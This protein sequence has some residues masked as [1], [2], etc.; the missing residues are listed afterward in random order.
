MPKSSRNMRQ[1]SVRDASRGEMSYRSLSVRS[2]TLD[3]D[4]RTVDAIVSTETPVLMPDWQRMEMVP[5]VLQ[6]KGA[7]IPPSGQVPFLD[8][9]NRS[10]VS[11]QLGSARKIAT[12]YND[13]VAT[14][15][16]S[17]AAD[18]EFTKVREGHVTDVSA[19]YEVLK[20]TYVP[21]G[22]TQQVNG[23]SYTGPVNVATKWRLR[24]VS[25]TP[26]GA[27]A[28]AK[29]RGLD[30][31]A[32][33]FESPTE[34]SFEMDKELRDFLVSRGM[35]ATLNDADAQKWLMANRALLV[36]APAPVTTSTAPAVPEPTRAA[37]PAPQSLPNPQPGLAVSEQRIQELFTASFRDFQTK[38]EAAR[39][40]FRA[41][42]DSLCELAGLPD[43]VTHCRDLP[44]IAAVRKHLTDEKARLATV[45]P[46]QPSI[47]QTGSGFD[48]CMRDMGT[49]LALRAMNNATDP[50]HPNHEKTFEKV[51]PVASRGKGHETFRHATIFRMAEEF[52]RMLGIDTRDMTR[53]DIAICAM[54]GPD[55]IGKRA[56]GVA[57]YNQTG[58]FT[59]LTLDAVNKSMMVGYVE[60][61]S[62]WEG[63][64][65]QAM[66]A[67]DF[68]QIHR[69]RMGAIPNLPVWNDNDNP[70]KASF[71]DAQE[72]YAVEARSLEIGFSYRLLVNDDMDAISRVPAMM[73]AAARRTV[74][75]VAWAQL[76][77]NPTMTDGQP[78]FS[79]PAGNRKRSN[80]TTGVN[81]PTVA[82][83]QVSSNLMRQMRGE[84]TPEGNESQDVL[85]LV[86][87]YIVGPGALAT[88]INQLVLSAYDPAANSFMVYNTATQLIPVIE[89]LLD[90]NSVA[91]WYLFASPAQIDTI[92]VTFLQGQESPIVRPF[93]DERN[94]S[95][96]FIVLQTF[97]AKAMN[98]RG[99]QQQVGA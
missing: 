56:G 71:A 65:R 4:N 95:Q 28:Q 7:I 57:A 81:L 41:E 58:N 2:S 78:L 12:R 49:A 16:F 75:A 30:P 66:S 10:R 25:L 33:R 96:N 6:A 79:A 8:S 46:F 48:A 5:E 3:T 52:V 24:E 77:S 37:A 84:N 15:H 70:T 13:L 9:H 61:P 17:S 55:K 50:N 51:L 64:M 32:F 43:A 97:A 92:E 45:V 88:S 54:F 42:V 98:H 38:Q 67:P 83:L 94:L 59:N 40:A 19:G 80:K 74:N 47:R 26:I 1:L 73:G 18:S 87:R 93:M 53:D 76:T 82:N 27:D 39:V 89:P 69:V 99:I 60:S 21:K 63:P 68:K 72:Q 14:L 23:R 20:K 36:D 34:E 91:S 35:V 29:L 11:D 85:N 31:A 86:P 90:A 22:E 62:T 44:D